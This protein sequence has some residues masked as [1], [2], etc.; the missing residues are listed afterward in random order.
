MIV[1]ID[2]R[3]GGGARSLSA[4][5]LTGTVPTELGELT[6]MTSLKL[7]DNSLTGTLPT[8]LGELTLMTYL[9]LS[10]NSLTGT[11]PTEL[12][13]L[14]LMTSLQKRVRG[15]AGRTEQGGCGSE[16]VPAAGVGWCRHE[17]ASHWQSA[18]PMPAS[19]RHLGQGPYRSALLRVKHMLERSPVLGRAELQGRRQQEAP[20]EGVWPDSVS[21]GGVAVPSQMSA[22]GP[23]TYTCENVRMRG[24]D[25]LGRCAGGRSL[26]TNMLTGTLPTE[27]GELTLMSWLQKRVWA[28]GGWP[29]HGAGRQWEWA[30]AGGVSGLVPAGDGQKLYDNSLTG[31][32][33]TELGEL[34]LMT[35]L[36]L[37]S[38]S[39]TGTLPTEL[40]ELTLIKQLSVC[41]PTEAGR[42][43][44][45]GGNGSGPVPAP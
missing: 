38:N 33:P 41:G 10:V 42:I 12:G 31:T 30:G 2:S 32:L 26:D 25:E 17:M 37:Q 21:A 36:W 28:D 13:E 35:Y 16:P 18:T 27:L 8:E 3:L 34:T 1:V 15:E 43:T 14:T 29:H 11:V 23:G 45:Q 24:C 9:E 6:L 7:Y 19:A 5:S 39:L 20:P 44:G 22:G 40:G 4:N